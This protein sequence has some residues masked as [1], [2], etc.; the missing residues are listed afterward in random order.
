MEMGQMVQDLSEM[1]EIQINRCLYEMGGEH[2]T[3][4][5]LHGFEDV[6]K[7]AYCAVVCLTYRIN[8]SRA[9][10]RLVARQTRVS[11]L[12][13]L[14]IPRLELMSARI[15]VELMSTIRNA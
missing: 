5:Y 4:C 3:E 14:S 2:V 6:S 7:E 11:P 9:H 12:K 8:D 13:E 15:L 1:G 10:A